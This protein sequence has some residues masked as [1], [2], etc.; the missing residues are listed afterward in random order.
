MDWVTNEA[1]LRFFI[2]LSVN[3]AIIENTRKES[4]CCI[5]S[6][7]VT[8]EVTN[9]I[10]SCWLFCFG[11]FIKSKLHIRFNSDKILSCTV[12]EN[13]NFAV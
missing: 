11:F 13:N 1:D 12:Y 4:S 8:T 10:F 5:V 9:H 2:K 6:L 3:T 7:F